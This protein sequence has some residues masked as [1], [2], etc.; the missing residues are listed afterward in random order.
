MLSI[1]RNVRLSVRPSVRL[2]VCLFTFEVPFNGLFAPTFWSW[3]SNIFRDSES[4]GKS[5]GKKWSRIWTFLF[6]NCLKPPR[7]YIYFFLLILR[8]V[9]VSRLYNDMRRLYWD[10]RRLY[11]DMRRL[12][13]DMRRLYWDMRRLYNDMRRLYWDMRWSY[14]MRVL[15]YS[16]STL[17]WHRCYYPH[18]SWDALSPVCGIFLQWMETLPTPGY[19][20]WSP[21]SN[22]AT[23]H[24]FLPILPDQLHQPGKSYG[25]HGNLFR[26]RPRTWRADTF[27]SLLSANL[28]CKWRNWKLHWNK[29]NDIH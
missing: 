3:M 28:W 12:Y 9:S 4:L 20:Q 6:E 22:S 16:W 13:W 8:P 5:N 23:H 26:N 10:M 29:N 19:L 21:S 27:L 14:M 18:R 25:A 17:L 15:G 7:N 24:L 1:S 11:N 2:S